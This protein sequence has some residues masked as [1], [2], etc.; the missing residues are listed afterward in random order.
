M[1]EGIDSR[2][3]DIQALKARL[4][5]LINRQDGNPASSAEANNELIA[6]LQ[7]RINELEGEKRQSIL[8]D[9]KQNAQ[10]EELKQKLAQT[11]SRFKS[12]MK[13]LQTLMPGN[14]NSKTN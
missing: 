9:E 13:R 12:V 11:E 2:D 3:N 5:E 6:L 8:E 4:E 7:K 1:R 10:I 14:I